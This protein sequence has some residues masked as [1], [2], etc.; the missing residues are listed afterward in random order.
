MF[1][2]SAS[3]VSVTVRA[4]AQ[5]IATAPFQPLAERAQLPEVLLTAR[6]ADIRAAFLALDDCAPL[7]DD[8]WT[9]WLERIAAHVRAS[10]PVELTLVPWCVSWTTI[11]VRSM[12]TGLPRGDLLTAAQS[13]GCADHAQVL[14]RADAVAAR[15]RAAGRKV[16]ITDTLAGVSER[17]AA[18]EAAK[19]P[20]HYRTVQVGI[21][22]IQVPIYE[23]RL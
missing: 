6:W 22:T 2:I 21:L 19:P 7:A 8:P 12:W 9:P 3:M 23:A 11:R 5:A 15:L 13:D 4:P 10:E 18:S 1:S 14:A 17:R 20:A 16:I